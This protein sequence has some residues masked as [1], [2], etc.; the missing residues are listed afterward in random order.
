MKKDFQSLL[1]DFIAW[2]EKD[3]MI[4]R[5]ERQRGIDRVRRSRRALNKKIREGQT[6]LGCR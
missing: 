1:G 6:A 3:G 5:W 2:M 4:G